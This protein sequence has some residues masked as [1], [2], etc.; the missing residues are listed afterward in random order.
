MPHEWVELSR[1]KLVKWGLKFNLNPLSGTCIVKC[2]I[3]SNFK[4]NVQDFGEHL[5]SALEQGAPCVLVP[6]S[7]VSATSGTVA[8][9][10]SLGGSPALLR[11][12]LET[13]LKSFHTRASVACKARW[14]LKLGRGETRL[15][16]TS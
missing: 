15:V 6:G 4:F 10:T 16:P 14:L 1:T 8:W 13:A 2:T 9:G 7:L 11:L 12:L 5:S 3:E